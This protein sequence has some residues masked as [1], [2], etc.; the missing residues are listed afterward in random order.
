MKR[1]G[2]RRKPEERTERGL[3]TTNDKFVVALSG[4][5]STEPGSL[6]SMMAG[7]TA[8][9]TGSQIELALTQDSMGVLCQDGVLTGRD[10]SRI[11]VSEYN[12]EQVRTQ[13]PMVV[14]LGQ[15]MELAKSMGHLFV[16]RLRSPRAA[17][18]LKTTLRYG[19]YESQSLVY[20]L[21]PEELA[22]V[23][24]RHPD[25]RMLLGVTAPVSQPERFVDQVHQAGLFG[26]LVRPD[27]L[28]EE[29]CQAAHRV[30]L[31]VGVLH[32]DGEEEI[33]Q[34]VEWGVNFILTDRPD[35]A[36]RHL[37]QDQNVPAPRMY[38]R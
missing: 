8:G 35:L 3:Y 27:H 5:L 17:D 24:A 18:I 30:G 12:F 23:Q 13:H 31:F 14:S 36:A 4:C 21:A 6:E 38:I 33:R 37:P 20:G 19:D 10:G 25:L 32:A 1:T 29:L 7:K 11:D 2:S 34:A 15:A 22:Q 28:T 16:V 9:A 26:L